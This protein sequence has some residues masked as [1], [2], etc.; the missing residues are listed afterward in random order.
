[1]KLQKFHP[2]DFEFLSEQPSE[3]HLQ[4]ADLKVPNVVW[5]VAWQVIVA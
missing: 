5:N 1:M 2:D 3:P 4:G